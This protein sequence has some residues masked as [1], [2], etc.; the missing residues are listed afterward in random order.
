[1]EV[2]HDLERRHVVENGR[3]QEHLPSRI[4]VVTIQLSRRRIG[5]V[6][7]LEV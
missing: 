2:L 7:R 5:T 1:M 6:I 3:V 4:G